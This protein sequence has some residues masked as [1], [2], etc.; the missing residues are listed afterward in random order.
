VRVLTEL[1]FPEV[2]AEAMKRS[3]RQH[4]AQTD[5][6]TLARSGNEKVVLPG[7][8]LQ[9]ECQQSFTWDK[10]KQQNKSKGTNRSGAN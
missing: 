2:G 9:I 5:R 4:V 6:S 8:L 10:T 1:R 3:R 7:H